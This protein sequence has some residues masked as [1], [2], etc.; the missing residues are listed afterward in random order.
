MFISFVSTTTLVD[1]FKQKVCNASTRKSF[2]LF[3]FVL[4]STVQG[5][6]ISADLKNE[7]KGY[8]IDQVLHDVE[9]NNRTIQ[10]SKRLIG[11]AQADV[12][13]ADVGQNPSLSFGAFNS[14]AKRYRYSE[15]DQTLRI[16]KTYER[17]D[18]RALRVAAA[19]QLV[20]ATQADIVE[21]IRQ[22]KIIG[23]DAYVDLMQS[24]R[25]LALS[26]ENEQNFKRLVDGA[27]KRLK[28][29]DIASADLSRLNVEFSRSSNEVRAAQSALLQAQ[30]KLASLLATEGTVIRAT[31]SLPNTDTLLQNSKFFSTANNTSALEITLLSRSDLNAANARVKA[32]EKAVELAKSQQIRDVT[33][34][35]QTERAPGFG[36]RVFGLSASIP[37]LT[38]N[39]YTSEALK[40]AAD[41]NVAEGEVLRIKAQIQL[42]VDT[43]FTQ[44]IGSKDRLE[45]LLGTT[46]PEVIKASQ[47]IEYAYSRGAATLTD[48]F[49][50]RRQFNAVQVETAAAQADFARALYL[51]KA[52]I[53]GQ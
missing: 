52:T 17:G 6:S 9:L 19:Q 28:A 13:R 8:S 22:Q 48:L 51:Y 16:E 34:G 1:E 44:L 32:F 50:S 12:K 42:E 29:G 14:I 3:A 35:A 24:Q 53:I 43:A 25:I 18:K 40:A 37:L 2:R 15:L 5:L 33:F 46:M 27:Q 23:A 21:I 4:L 10:N 7:S 39:D 20:T 31:D 41:L 11:V 30:F 45:R 26:E 36:G 47:A 38:G 49:D